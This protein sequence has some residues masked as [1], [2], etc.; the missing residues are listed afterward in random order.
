MLDI[1]P[2]TKIDT[3]LSKLGQALESGD[4]DAAV[5][6]FQADCYWR[7]LVTFTWNLKTLEG[8]EQIRDML[9]SQLAA[10]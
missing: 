1:S 2:G 8:H 6:L 3:M 5:N 9:T 7:D 4:I 10:T